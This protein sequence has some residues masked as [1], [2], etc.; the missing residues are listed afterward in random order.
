MRLP[1]K[2]TIIATLVL[3]LVIALW[4]CFG[5][6]A[7][8]AGSKKTYGNVRAKV[9]EVHDGDTIKVAVKDWPPLIGDGI[10]VRVYG[11]DTRELKTGATAAK[12]AVSKWIP[13]DSVVWLGNLRRDKY[14]RILAD[15]YFDCGDPALISTCDNLAAKLIEKKLGVPYF[16]DAKKEFPTSIK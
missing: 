8:Y 14:F 2:D 13:V 12:D 10:G 11:V 1:L 6:Y 5:V 7:A 9:I 3:L 15:V 16:G 4:I